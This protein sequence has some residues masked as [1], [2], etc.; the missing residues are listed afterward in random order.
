MMGIDCLCQHHPSPPFIFEQF[1]VCHLVLNRRGH[2][3]RT[4][5]WTVVL[6]VR[7]RPSPRGES[8]FTKC[9][10]RRLNS[11]G[12]ERRRREKSSILKRGGVYY[13]EWSICATEALGIITKPP[14]QDRSL[15]HSRLRVLSDRGGRKT[16]S[17]GVRRG[18]AVIDRTLPLTSP[19]THWK[20]SGLGVRTLR[21]DSEV[22]ASLSPWWAPIRPSPTSKA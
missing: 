9:G 2:R 18:L 12:P 16:E 6:V 5:Q 22:P 7:G 20:N 17:L 4:Q 3:G 11:L 19:F 8:P 10:R 1:F 14:N 15:L 13:R 21:G